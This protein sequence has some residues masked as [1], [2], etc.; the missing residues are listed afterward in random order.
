LRFCDTAEDVLPQLIILLTAFKKVVSSTQLVSAQEGKA[1]E[2]KIKTLIESKISKSKLRFKTMFA[3]DDDDDAT[4]ETFTSLIDFLRIHVS[5]SHAS[6]RFLS[7]DSF[8]STVKAIMTTNNNQAIKLTGV[9]T[10]SLI[11]DYFTKKNSNIPVKLFDDV[12]LRYI[13]YA[14]E[15]M[16][17]SIVLAFIHGKTPFLRSEAY[18]LYASI[19][20]KHKVLSTSSLVL[21]VDSLDGYIESVNTAM[22]SNSD[23]GDEGKE[24]KPKHLETILGTCKDVASFLLTHSSEIKVIS[25]RKHLQEVM[26]SMAT[27]SIKASL[28][29]IAEQVLKIMEGPKSTIVQPVKSNSSVQGNKDSK[30]EG[31]VSD[32]KSKKRAV[33]VVTTSDDKNEV[34]GET[35]KKSSKKVK[36]SKDAK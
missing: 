20:K 28:H 7:V 27:L 34:L 31:E 11:N 26:S 4:M 17:P 35:S 29:R 9:V 1:F 12:L 25:A 10:S 36:K 16:L 6:V 13:D 33:E 15:Y 5:S 18:R 23:K 8:V 2:S 19:L 30:K 14:I 32:K 22:T 24:L 3:N 21:V